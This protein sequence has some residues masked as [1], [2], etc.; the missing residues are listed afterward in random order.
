M[1]TPAG[2][3]VQI[4]TLRPGLFCFRSRGFELFASMDFDGSIQIQH[5]QI[6]Y[7]FQKCTH[8]KEA[9]LIIFTIL[10]G[11]QEKIEKNPEEFKKLQKRK[12]RKLRR[13]KNG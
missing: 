11:I 7:K 8:W 9:E 6:N 13:K 5:P 10:D 12:N 3:P 4:Q 1:K 2:H